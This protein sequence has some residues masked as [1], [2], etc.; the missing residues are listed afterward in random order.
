MRADKIKQELYKQWAGMPVADACAK[1]IDCLQKTP[2]SETG[3]LTYQSFLNMLDKKNVD[4][5]LLAAVSI[6]SA[7][8]LAILDPHALFIDD[9]TEYEL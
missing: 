2:A 1:I 9:E 6:L 5:E 7:S 3:F 8:K 4:E